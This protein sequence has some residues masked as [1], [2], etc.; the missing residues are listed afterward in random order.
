MSTVE[1]I[2]A[3]RRF[4]HW[5]LVFADILLLRGGFDLILGN[6]PWIKVEWNESGVLSERNPVF[7]IRKISASDLVKLRAEAF[8][9]FSGLREVWTEEFQ[10]ADGTQN[11]LNATQNY[12]MLRGMKANLYKCFIPLAWNLSGT[13]GISA[14]LHPEGPYDDLNGAMLRATAYMRLRRQFRFVN[15]LKLFSEVHNQTQ[16][17]INIYGDTRVLPGFDQISN[18]FTPTT[19][20]ACY[21]HAGTGAVGGYK[22]EDGRWNTGGHSDRIIRVDIEALTTYAQLYDAP[23]L[24][25][26]L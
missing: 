15:E 21:Q 22:T 25:T 23:N 11:F 19:V 17:S 9:D 13:N 5:E 24:C 18:L 3:T 7:A 6:P 10:E 26:A 1:D 20:D 2:A 14:L 12:P 8:R 4:M 16:F